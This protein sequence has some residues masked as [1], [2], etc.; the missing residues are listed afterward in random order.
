MQGNR[1]NPPRLL[2][3]VYHEL[4]PK[5]SSAVV[6][7]RGEPAIR[8][9]EPDMATPL[10]NKLE[11]QSLESSDDFIGPQGGNPGH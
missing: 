3:Y 5:F 6:R 4:S 9:P 1:R 10:T 8:V 7:N 2:E 11:P